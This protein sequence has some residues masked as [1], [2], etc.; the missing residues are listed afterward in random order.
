MLDKDTMGNQVKV[1]LLGKHER[2]G[3]FTLAE[4]DIDSK[5]KE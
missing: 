5:L 1:S 4:N 2:R 3:E